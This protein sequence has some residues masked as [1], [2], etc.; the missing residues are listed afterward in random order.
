M[1]E[2]ASR[3]KWRVIIPNVTLG[4]QVETLTYEMVHIHAGQGLRGQ[5]RQKRGRREEREEER[6]KEKK[7]D[8]NL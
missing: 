7:F 2:Q 6:G 1:V 3:F 4:D 8:Q 5:P